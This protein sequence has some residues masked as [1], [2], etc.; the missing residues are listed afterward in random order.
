M[1]N[2]E[3]AANKIGRSADLHIP[4]VAFAASLSP[5]G[6]RISMG[7]RNGQCPYGMLIADGSFK[8]ITKASG[9]PSVCEPSWSSDGHY[10]AFTGVTQSASGTDGRYDVF[11][12]EATGLAACNV[13]VRYG[14]RLLRL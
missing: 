4:R 10:I 12:A 11:I 5:D 13:S 9:R 7:G 3:S 8:L 1:V 6:K 2:A 14:G